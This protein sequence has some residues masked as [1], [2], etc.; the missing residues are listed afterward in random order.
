MRYNNFNPHF[1]RS[2]HRCVKHTAVIACS[3]QSALLQERS[4]KSFIFAS[5][6]VIFQSALLQERSQQNKKISTKFR[7]TKLNRASGNFQGNYLVLRASPRVK[8]TN[9]ASLPRKLPNSHHIFVVFNHGYIS[10]RAPTRAIIL[11]G[12][13]KALDKLFQSALL[14]ERSS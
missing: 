1:Y 6:Q 9:F 13:T 3:F 7:K 14:Q 2:D 10:I 8:S 5:K 12:K 11:T 4:L